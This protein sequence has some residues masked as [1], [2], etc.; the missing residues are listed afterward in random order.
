M[1]GFRK[2]SEIEAL[3][4]RG[5]AVRM[6]VVESMTRPIEFRQYETLRGDLIA[7]AHRYRG[8][9]DWNGT[10]VDLVIDQGQRGV[11]TVAL[12][13]VVYIEWQKP[14]A[15]TSVLEVR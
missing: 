13:R 1:K 10:C 14:T 8:T 3:A 7:V 2:Y 5:E 6:T 4:F 15:A 12:S 11:R 9:G